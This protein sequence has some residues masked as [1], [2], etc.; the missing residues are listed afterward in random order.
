[1]TTF[2]TKKKKQTSCV[3]IEYQIPSGAWLPWRVLAT[4]KQADQVIA[5]RP[6]P[7]S[8]CRTREVEYGMRKEDK[9]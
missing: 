4:K 9:A 1:M 7:T 2:G 5:S 6:N 8:I 3:I